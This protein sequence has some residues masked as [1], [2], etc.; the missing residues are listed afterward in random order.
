MRS[1]VILDDSL[2][3][4]SMQSRIKLEMI[5]KLVDEW[6]RLDRSTDYI[7]PADEEHDMLG[8]LADEIAY[9][10]EYAAL[11]KNPNLSKD[12]IAELREE[13]IENFYKEVDEKKNEP[14]IRMNVIEEMLN[15][16]GV[17]LA[18]PYEHHNEMESYYDYMESRYSSY[19]DY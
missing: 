8:D 18:R 11:E 15:V 9:E 12:E 14:L 5:S 19:D 10:A 7:C 4:E 17:R 13:A 6:N 2:N 1:Y 3:D 16:L